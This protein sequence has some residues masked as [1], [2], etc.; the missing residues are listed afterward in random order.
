[1]HHCAGL[2]TG[3]QL[4]LA[5]RINEHVERL[6]G[7]APPEPPQPRELQRRPMEMGGPPGYFGGS[8]FGG[9]LNLGS[10]AFWDDSFDDDE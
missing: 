8:V 3:E 9:P 2:S 1:V 6:T 10:P 5:Q 4:W 7:N